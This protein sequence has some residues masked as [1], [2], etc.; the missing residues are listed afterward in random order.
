MAAESA[1]VLKKHTLDSDE[2][3]NL[4]PDEKL[5]EDDI[6]GQEEETIAFDGSITITPFNM[7]EEM[8]TG[9]FDKT[10]TYIFDKES[11]IKDSWM[12]DIDWV[13]VKQDAKEPP[14]G[15]ESSDSEPEAIDELSVWKDMVPLMKPGESVAKS[16]RRL[17][18]GEKKLT[19]AQ[20]LKAKKQGIKPTEEELENRKA[21]QALTGLA[22]KLIQ[23]GYME[24][25]EDT[26]EKITYMVKQKEEEL[27]KSAKVSKDDAA[28]DMFGE[29]F[30]EKQDEGAPETK[31]VKFEEATTKR[32]DSRNANEVQWE[33]K[34]QNSD[35]AEICGPFS[36]TY[37]QKCVD[38]NKFPDGVFVRK[39]GSGREFY[40]SKRIDF[41]LYT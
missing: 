7:R 2:E 4:V 37:M 6:E 20:R 29:E 27:N 39:V 38:D 17:G 22:D 13:K 14:G 28:L 36:S 21:F 31:R 11:E 8:E 16:L 25:Y 26:Y 40:T 32:E 35:D 23:S 15:N 19:S 12:D 30:D 33:Y 1:E 10:G 41:D 24:I 5:D 9:H 34:W 18:G 3:D